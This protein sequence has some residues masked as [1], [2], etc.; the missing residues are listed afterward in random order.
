[1]NAVKWVDRFIEAFTLLCGGHEPPRRMV[2][3]WFDERLDSVDLQDF[4]CEFTP[5]ETAQGIAIID[6]AICIANQP[7]EGLN[8]ETE[9]SH[10][11]NQPPTEGETK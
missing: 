9:F 3:D 6:A 11:P 2:I 7:V 8:M 10:Y 1:M 4:A 5:L